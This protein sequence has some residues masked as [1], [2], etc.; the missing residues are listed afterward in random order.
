[1]LSR[2]A[3]FTVTTYLAAAEVLLVVLEDARSTQKNYRVTGLSPESILQSGL[4]LEGEIE[5][6][7]ERV[8]AVSGA[9]LAD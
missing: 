4:V 7:S 1:M 9:T 5:E 2:T 6:V 8:Y 3:T